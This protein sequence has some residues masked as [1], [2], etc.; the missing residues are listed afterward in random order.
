MSK[1]GSYFVVDAESGRKFCVEPIGDPHETW[2]DLDPVTK[3]MTGSYG[4]KYPGSIS[5]KDSIITEENG[6]KNITTL[7]IGES[8]QSYIDKLLNK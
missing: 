1:T 5:E 2:G 7:G 8:P 3:K 4:E 6:F